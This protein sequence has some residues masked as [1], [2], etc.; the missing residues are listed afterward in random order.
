[1]SFT[2]IFLSIENR[3]SAEDSKQGVKIKHNFRYPACWI[4]EMDLKHSDLDENGVRITVSKMV[5]KQ[6]KNNMLQKCNQCN[7]ASFRESNLRTHLKTHSGEKSHKCNQCDYASP[8]VS[9]LRT[10]LITHSGEKSNKCN[11]CDYASF[12][13][14]NLRTHLK[15]HSGEKSNKCN[16]CD[17]TSSYPSNLRRH[18]KKH[19]GEKSN[20]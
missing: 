3:R 4:L 19:S 15:T 1:M 11:Q 5:T 2:L 20:N 7:F 8:H 14:S 13:A 9:A 17:F 10:H 12:Q 16:Q 18:L 6:R